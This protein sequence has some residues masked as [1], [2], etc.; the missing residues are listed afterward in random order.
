VRD[1]LHRVRKRLEFG[2]PKWWKGEID[3]IITL[4]FLISAVMLYKGGCTF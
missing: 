2:L 1:K 3:V 4:G